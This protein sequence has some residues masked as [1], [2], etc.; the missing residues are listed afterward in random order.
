M[1]K[2]FQT[3]K[4][5]DL[6]LSEKVYIRVENNKATLI[7]FDSRGSYKS[8]LNDLKL[9]D[10]EYAF[11]KDD[12]FKAIKIIGK[13]Y[14]VS[15]RKGSVKFTNDVTD[16]TIQLL[17]KDDFSIN[18]EGLTL[19]DIPEDFLSKFAKVSQFVSKNENEKTK[20]GNVYLHNNEM[21]ATSGHSSIKAILNTELRGDT[22]LPSDLL[23]I[24]PN[25]LKY[26]LHG[27]T[28]VVE[29]EEGIAFLKTYDHAQY[30]LDQLKAFLN[31]SKEG[32]IVVS[33]EVQIQEV[34]TALSNAMELG[35]K[36][37]ELQASNG[38]IKAIDDEKANLPEFVA[39][40]NLNVPETTKFTAAL[41]KK[42]YIDKELY[43]HKMVR[44][45]VSVNTLMCFTDNYVTLV[46]PL[47]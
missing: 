29:S 34:H 15:V 39:T 32:L 46:M 14:E 18:D 2:Y 42:S 24:V 13:N 30:P 25:P 28:L 8:W 40:L 41:V 10:G 3:K 23:S 1:A 36:S 43:L 37:I 31:V 27:E 33:Q 47:R 5:K 44:G 9:P 4:V 26:G 17:I 7:Q 38:S 16:L 35:Y 12:F 21:Y 19:H 11:D 45:Q 22:Y 6:K 20:L